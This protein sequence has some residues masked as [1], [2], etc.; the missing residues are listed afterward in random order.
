[1]KDF[2]QERYN[3]IL[4][5]VT[6]KE[7]KLMTAKQIAAVFGVPKQEMSIL[8]KII[9]K[10]ESDGK[11]YVDDSKRICVPNN[12]SKF[13][14]KFEAKS[15]GFGFARVISTNSNVSDIYISREM[16]NG[17]FEGDTVLVDI[18]RKGELGK[19]L[20]GKVVKIIQRGEAK[21]VGIVRKND[22]FGFVEV[23]NGTINDIYIP[24]KLM[25]GV[26]NNDRVVVK[27]TK[28]P[29][30]TRKAEGKISFGRC[31]YAFSYTHSPYSQS[32]FIRYP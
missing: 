23:L 27:I 25:R 31:S 28:Y 21:F 19:N 8:E 3:K 5:Y 1:M 18:I 30:D 12:A 15:R 24:F 22:S 2:E 26:E 17:A 32:C 11:I 4:E 13:I 7:Y 10:L 6:S 16:T 14:C 29:T 20:E 9:N